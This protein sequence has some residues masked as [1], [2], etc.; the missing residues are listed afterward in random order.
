MSPPVAII[1]GG[2]SGLTAAT[3][4]RR[5][6][7][8]FT[9]YEAAGAL[10][11]LATTLHDDDGFAYDFGAHF[12][13]NRLAAAVGAGA[14]CYDVSRYGESVN[15]HGRSLSYPFGLLTEKRFLASA[16]AQKTK[17][18][19]ARKPVVNAADWFEE[20]YGP[21]L[22]HEVALPLLEAWS[23]LPAH[24]LAP[25]VGE[26]L[27]SSIVRTAYLKVA[28]LL[29]RRAVA[30]GY[31]HS[32]PESANVWHVYPRNGVAT[33]CERMAVDVADAIEYESRATAIYVEDGRVSG[34]RINDR[35]IAASAVLC[36]APLDVVARMVRGTSELESLKRFRYRPM[37][38]VN[39][40]LDGRNLLSNIVV[41]TPDDSVPYFRLS[42]APA[43][44][45][46]LAPPNMTTVT[47]DIGARVGDEHWNMTDDA[48][49][50]LCVEHLARI[51]PDVRRRYRGCRVMRT[52]IAY[53]VFAL[54]Y[55][56]LRQRLE[57]GS[58]VI[59]LHL[60]GRNGEFRHDLME[61]VFWR[62]RRRA[63]R[64]VDE[65]GAESNSRSA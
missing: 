52:P 48:L 54:E 14:E 5:A 53:P 42:E 63:R 57:L 62:T 58:G 18:S 1:G 27:P 26:Q 47:C 34:V 51:I 38:F 10:G 55:E 33:L 21:A 24:E 45:P 12:I 35:D 65:F 44:M 22:A 15:L 7:V 13:T 9:L 3:T 43:A 30:S 28:A 36:S 32:Q 25:V 6:G 19:T 29:T 59:G 4:L 23:G 20:R 41:W 11:G 46:S 49:G 64:V 40:R 56:P 2:I 31:C 50:D 39:V 8:P 16:L 17:P 37:I 60:I 61:D